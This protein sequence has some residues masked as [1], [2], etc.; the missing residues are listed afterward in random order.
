MKG[1]KYNYIIIFEGYCFLD[2]IPVVHDESAV[3]AGVIKTNFRMENGVVKENYRN[4]SF[5]LELSLVDDGDEELNFWKVLLYPDASGKLCGQ[6]VE[7]PLRSVAKSENQARL[8]VC[9]SRIEKD[10]VSPIA[11][12]DCPRSVL[13][14]GQDCDLQLVTTEDASISE[15]GKL[16]L[17]IHGSRKEKLSTK[18]RASSVVSASQVSFPQPKDHPVSGPLSHPEDAKAATGNVAKDDDIPKKVSAT[19]QSASQGEVTVATSSTQPPEPNVS[20]A[21]SNGIGKSESS[22]Q[23]NSPVSTTKPSTEKVK[24]PPKSKLKPSNSKATPPPPRKKPPAPAK[25]TQQGNSSNAASDKPNLPADKDSMKDSVPTQKI[26]DET[27]FEAKPEVHQDIET[28]GTKKEPPAPTNLTEDETVSE[29]QPDTQQ[30]ARASAHPTKEENVFATQPGNLQTTKTAPDVSAEPKKFESSANEE[31]GETQRSAKTHSKEEHIDRAKNEVKERTSTKVTEF[32]DHSENRKLND[33]ETVGAVEKQ[34]TQGSSNQVNDEKTVHDKAEEQRDAE[35]PDTTGVRELAV[36]VEKKKYSDPKADQT[37]VTASMQSNEESRD[38]ADHSKSKRAGDGKSSE[39]EDIAKTHSRKEKKD[40]PTPD[41]RRH[42]PAEEAREPTEQIRGD[43]ST[44][45]KSC[46]AED[47]VEKHLK[48]AANKLKDQRGASKDITGSSAVTRSKEERHSSKV[49][50]KNKKTA[51]TKPGELTLSKDESHETTG[52]VKGGTASTPGLHSKQKPSDKG[53][54]TSTSGAK[55]PKTNSKLPATSREIPSEENASSAKR[56]GNEKH[57]EKA[58]SKHETAHAERHLTTSG[59][60]THPNENEQSLDVS[61]QAV[62]AEISSRKNPVEGTN[63]GMSDASNDLGMGQRGRSEKKNTERG[64]EVPVDHDIQ[65]GEISQPDSGS[66]Q[67]SKQRSMEDQGEQPVGK[68]GLPPD[69]SASAAK[70]YRSSALGNYTQGSKPLSAFERAREQLRL[71]GL[72][73]DPSDRKKGTSKDKAAGSG[74]VKDTHAVPSTDG[75]NKDGTSS[76]LPKSVSLSRDTKVDV[77]N[78]E[79]NNKPVIEDMEVPDGQQNFQLGFTPH[80]AYSVQ[81]EP[82]KA[83]YRD[84]GNS[85]ESSRGYTFVST[86]QNVVD[87]QLNI[88]FGFQSPHGARSGKIEPSKASYSNDHSSNESGYR[89]DPVSSSQSTFGTASERRIVDSKETTQLLSKSPAWTTAPRQRLNSSKPKELGSHFT[90]V[91]DPHSRSRDRPWPQ[92]QRPSE[93]TSNTFSRNETSAHANTSFLPR[94]S[95]SSPQ[96]TEEMSVLCSDDATSALDWEHQCT[97]AISNAADLLRQRESLKE[98]E[99]K[100][101]PQLHEYQPTPAQNL[102]WD[103]L[104]NVIMNAQRKCTR[105]RNIDD[106]RE[107]IVMLRKTME[108]PDEY[109][110]LFRCMAVACDQIWASVSQKRKDEWSLFAHQSVPALVAETRHLVFG[111]ARVLTRFFDVQDTRYIWQVIRQ[112]HAAVSTDLKFCEEIVGTRLH[113]VRLLSAELERAI[114]E[115]CCVEEEVASLYGEEFA[116]SAKTQGITRGR[117][118]NRSSPS[119]LEHNCKKL[120]REIEMLHQSDHLDYL[121]QLTPL[122]NTFTECKE[123]CDTLKQADVE[124]GEQPL[125]QQLQRQK[126]LRMDLEKMIEKRE[127]E[128]KNLSESKEQVSQQLDQ[129]KDEIDTSNASYSKET[130][131]AVNETLNELPPYAYKLFDSLTSPNSFTSPEVHPAT[132]KKVLETVRQSNEEFEASKPDRKRIFRRNLLEETKQEVENRQS[133]VLQQLH[134]SLTERF[135]STKNNGAERIRKFYHSEEVQ[136]LLDSYKNRVAKIRENRSQMSLKKERLMETLKCIETKKNGID[137]YTKEVRQLM[138]MRK[139]VRQ[140]W[141][142]AAPIVRKVNKG[143]QPIQQRLQRLRSMCSVERKKWFLQSCFDA[144]P[145][146]SDFFEALHAIRARLL[147]TYAREKTTRSHFNGV[148]TPAPP[149]NPPANVEMLQK[150]QQYLSPR[151]SIPNKGERK[152]TWRD[153]DGAD[154]DSKIRSHLHLSVHPPVAAPQDDRGKQRVSFQSNGSRPLPQHSTPS[155]TSPESHYF[156]GVT[157]LLEEARRLRS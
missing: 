69:T 91:V 110:W 106:L 98:V 43:K 45:V 79:V 16:S 102:R 115:L 19:T 108:I 41:K 15:E 122:W 105:V 118:G 138:R 117:L 67:D 38:L 135:N 103:N 9:I 4:C 65:E 20:T 119:D 125:I 29:M 58:V 139:T 39:V 42:T 8:R 70:R 113:D 149:N 78:S 64:P 51:D 32:T 56:S 57:V 47:R 21:S 7:I 147:L 145:Y 28:Y 120:K 66:V 10:S 73:M 1:S 53:T 132:T 24:K 123:I 84:S 111:F 18:T 100:V 13:L 50:T 150:P 131:Q 127:T 44:Y 146:S 2:M 63:F 141:T 30:E 88:T 109:K 82:F 104:Q 31:F 124:K 22:Q 81:I 5:I 90:T 27:L 142:N 55:N 6:Q 48:E 140:L 60:G 72:R 33:V 121:L 3:S 12:Y 86:G 92:S 23:V 155:T 93:E 77:W 54:F 157:E 95:T 71:G 14:E 99:R 144:A 89:Q 75:T 126:T 59:V 156:E 116:S 112:G 96:D 134:A 36:Q 94:E 25:P 61:G 26:K 148:G 153:N 46:G 34:E 11:M 129:L 85:Q 137:E 130:H 52:P 74:P 151:T 136:R 76:L 87:D 133:E 143:K 40:D 83:S 107:E 17:S 152:V 114:R 35:V 62:D 154:V 37:E 49:R 68:E 80:E 97:K 128:C 101:K